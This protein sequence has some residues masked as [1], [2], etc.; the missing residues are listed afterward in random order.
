[1]DQTWCKSEELVNTL[2]KDFKCLS[3]KDVIVINGG[4]N[5]IG[6][7]R[8]QTN[9][10]LIKMAQFM[11]KHSNSNIIV[12]TIPHRYDLDRNSVISLEIQAVN[13]KLN[14]M[15]K[16]FSHVA[17]VETDLNRNYFTRHSMH[18]NKSGE[19]WLSKLIATQICRLVSSNNKAVPVIPLNWE[20]EFTDKQNTVNSLSEQK[21]TCPIILDW[22]K[23]VGSVA[24]DKSLKR[25]ITRNRKLPVTRS[26]DLLW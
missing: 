18:L 13:R 21:T 1:L 15:A 14:N 10:V 20:D 25:V 19:E 12:V 24:E 3:K 4:A 2:E 9:M 5:D 16:V 8:N 7:M 11:Q 22:N 23:P 17:I 6:S 26:K